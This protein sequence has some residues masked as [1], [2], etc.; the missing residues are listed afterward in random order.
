[1]KQP[2]TR[3]S[4]IRTTTSVALGLG[5]AGPRAWA[6]SC[7][8]SES[9]PFKISLA[10]W[11]IHRAHRGGKID[12]VDFPRLAKETFDISAVE[13]VNQ[14]YR[15]R[16]T[17][18]AFFNE[19]EKRASDQGVKSLLIMVDGE[20]SLGEPEEAARKGVV[21]NHYKWVDA[22]AILG[23]HSIRVNAGGPGDRETLAP[24]VVDGLGRLS[25]YAGKAGLNVIV[26]NHGGYSS[27]GA[28]LANVIAQV[29]MDNCGTLPDFGNF[30]IKRGKDA[31]GKRICLE[32]YD[33]YKGV[34]ELMPYAKAVSA[35]S[36]DFDEDGNEIHTDFFRMMKIVLEAGYD[37]Y[38]G[39]EYEG[40]RDDEFTGIRKT[41]ALLE[42]VGTSY[43]S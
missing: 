32:E 4:F 18:E 25:E 3:R 39:I 22:A 35:K 9:M 42:K 7:C 43:T 26:E 2:Q 5:L 27:D 15:E 19:L 10:Q 17:D 28:W 16:G 11:S 30:C 33:R 20:G 8:G 40:S 37:G 41:K 13:Y 24:A 31:D 29:G 21:E 38:V 23:C 1:M 12:P 14:F 36:H 6:H 34:A